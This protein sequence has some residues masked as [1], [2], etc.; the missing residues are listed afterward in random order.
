M[1][2]RI[3]AALVTL[4][5]APWRRAPLL[6]RRRPGVLATV[7][8]AGAV[9]AASMA[10]VPLFLSSVGTESVALQVAER[11]PRDT[12]ATLSFLASPPGVR[13]PA[14]DPFLPLADRVGPGH[15]WVRL[16]SITIG[17]PGGAGERM[18]LL[19]RDDA[20]D[21]VDV[22]EGGGGQGA[23]L[24]DR[25]AEMTGLGVGDVAAIGDAEVPVVGIYR[26]LAGA[27]VDDFWC[28]NADLVLIESRGADLR[29]PPPMVLV[30]ADTFA[31]LMGR[32]Q[33]EQARGA[34]EAALRD[35]LTVTD[36]RALVPQLACSTEDAPVLTW[37][38]GGD[39]P[40]VARTRQRDFS[41]RDVAAQSDADF[42]ERFLDSHLPFVNER[43]RA[44]Q[45]SV[46]GGI[47]PVAG[48]AGLAGVGLVAAAASLWFDRRRR[49][50]TLLTV[51][52]VSPAGLGLKAV[53]E[54]SIPSVVG[55]VAGIALAYGM[56]VW[57]G[58]S[59]VLEGSALVR[60]AQAGLLSLLGAA[61][62]IWVVVANRVRTHGVHGRRRIRLALLPWELALGWATLVSFDRLGDWGLPAGRGADISRV[63]VWGL[64]FPVLFLVTAV[65]VLSRVIGW[66]LRPLRAVSRSWPTALY[67][68]VRRVARYRVAVIGLGAAAAVAAG[69]LGYAATMNRSLDATLQAKARTFVGSDTAVHIP[70]AAEMPPALADRTTEVHVHQDAWIVDGGR[71]S[72]MVL[73]ID[74][75]TFERGAYWDPTFADAPLRAVLDRLAMP[76]ERG[77]IPAVLVGAPA[78]ATAQ[79][80]IRRGVTQ[81]LTV[82]PIEGVSAFPGM[83]RPEPTIVVADSVLADLGLG[84]GTRELWISG[85]RD[86]ALQALDASDTG[87]EEEREVARVAGGASFVTVSWTFGFM[88]SLGISAGLLV[89]GGIAVYL[90]ARRRDRL[91]GYAFMRR[92]GLSGGQHRRALGAELTASVL[93]GCWTGLGI[94]L[95]AAWLAHQHIDPVPGYR[96]DPVLRP[97]TAM[98]ASLATIA[99]ILAVVATFL[100]Q[101]RVDRDDPVEVLRAG[102]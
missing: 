88:Q 57:L 90:D 55:A 26:D 61:A 37:C 51:R 66:V 21:H 49:E 78:G 28:S 64:M 2:D 60:A 101:R 84:T 36:T 79:I 92:M 30:D 69:V 14:P 96:P 91:L 35:D 68:A 43:S 15:R 3:R 8:G 16:E 87:F 45:T 27:T 77:V 99:V 81:E 9:M 65:A 59:P 33:I 73:G 85:D 10:A 39:R 100:A 70:L 80:A 102:V 41:L 94:A 53:L 19:Y 38:A 86:T 71:D 23:W 22:V 17:A 34:W 42:V 47:W 5:S 20:L 95:A 97:A 11:C 89:V 82:A 72:A 4:W 31:S 76:P 32:L 63:D 25:A 44:I 48:F 6:L 1:G 56:V 52:G 12:G 93:I 83:S 13:S 46:G 24:T 29:L 74:P 54:L 18:S 40:P 98:V 75:A 67:L 62:T 7:A 58:P 50:I